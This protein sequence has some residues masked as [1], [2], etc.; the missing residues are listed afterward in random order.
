MT[1]N[2]RFV[3]TPDPWSGLQ[4]FT[5][6]RIGL[7]RCGSSLPLKQ[8]LEFKLAQARARDAV[9]QPANLE[10]IAVQLNKRAYSSLQLGSSVRD[11]EEYLRRPDK[12]RCLSGESQKILE[13]QKKGYDLSIVIC[14]GLSAP[15]IHQ[16]ASGV[17]GG[18]LDLFRKTPL[19]VAPTSL[20]KNGRVAIGD[21]IGSALGAQMTVVLIGERPG[22]SSPNSLG[23]YLTYGPK[24][25]TTDEAR[26][27][28][29]N[30]RPGGMAVEEAVRKISY[31]IEKALQQRQT[32][33]EL[34]D[35]M[36]EDYLPMAG[37]LD[38]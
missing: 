8:R 6:A 36:A 30:I 2:N 16:S 10:E 37:L 34:K 25:G 1:E 21:E 22:L 3:Y 9:H 24:P 11:R 33:I 5:D 32:G 7:G 17:A 28:V 23:A 18:L 31:L 27:C 15:A 29:S 20:V 26:N 13:V 4:K 35:T 38:S 12:G 19:T 14:D